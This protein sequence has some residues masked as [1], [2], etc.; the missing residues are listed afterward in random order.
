MAGVLVRLRRPVLLLP[1][2]RA[3]GLVLHAL[4]PDVAVVGQRDVGEQRVAA[5]RWCASRSGWSSSWCPA[6]RR[7]SRTPGSP[8]RA[9]RRRRSASTRCR[10]RG[11]R[12]SSRGSVGLEHREVGLAAGGRERRGDVVHLLLRA[13]Q[14]EDQH[15]LGE[16]AL[17]ARHRR[18]DPQRVALLAQQG[19]AAVA[20]AEAP[21]QALLGEVR[22]VLGVVAR[23]RRRPLARLER[24]AERVQRRG[25]SRLASAR[26]PVEQAAAPRRPSAS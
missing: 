2:G 12:P 15:V 3:G 14:L 19:V 11:S 18:G 4:P 5:A 7:R 6:R 24:G 13:D 21:D 25:R 10:R 23:P 26:R 22:D 16:P 17:V 8:R 1:R 9:G 20:G